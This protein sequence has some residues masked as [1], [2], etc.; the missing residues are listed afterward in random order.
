V[1]DGRPAARV[2]V[3]TGKGGVGKSTVAAA[4]AV[5]LAA[6][7]RRTLVVSTDAAHSLA[8]VLD[9]PVGDRPRRVAPRLDA[10]QVEGQ[11]RLEGGWREI[12]D[13][14][15]SLL[16]WGGAGELEAA[17][18]ALLPG[19]DEVFA[20]LD[21]FDH[22]TSGRYDAVV[23]DCAPTAETLRLL[24]LP[25]TVGW[26]IE[27][28]LPVQRRVAR[29]LR[30]AAARVTSM[31]LPADGVF[32]AVSTLYQR[33]QEARAL[34]LDPRRTTV[35]MVVTPDRVVVAEARRLLTSLALFGH[36]VDAVVVNRLVPDE[37]SDPFLAGW[38][39][40]Q[41]RTLAEV[42][43][44]FG[45]LPRLPVPLLGA[46]PVGVPAL[47][48]LARGLYGPTDPAAVLADA[49]RLQVVDDPARPAL[50]L[51]LPAGRAGE[52]DLLQRGDELYVR[53]G[54][55]TRNLVL[56]AGLR[57]REVRSATVADGWL[58]VA[59]APGAQPVP[60]DRVA[61]G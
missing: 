47:A 16:A 58:T 11:R 53:V 55:H 4:T 40:R 25:E 23:V 35:R 8:D 5:H 31:P 60:Q 34:L 59:F 30:P 37:A 7:G 19:L 2:L 57:D 49:P 6:A 15:R 42:D 43:A 33:L 32:G 61:A 22:A 10:E 45:T 24:S 39:D 28:L 50:R 44:T 36:A 38:R 20:L 56:P 26:Y 9:H 48:A 52:V 29:A 13:Y 21:L 27:R 3:H 46:E 12:G 54:G 51:P 14:L 41:Q 18:L 17:E 1:T